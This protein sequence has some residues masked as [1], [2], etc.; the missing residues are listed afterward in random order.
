MA[1]HQSQVGCGL[2]IFCFVSLALTS[3][4]VMPANRPFS[5]VERGLRY[6]HCQG[7]SSAVKNTSSNFLRESEAAAVLY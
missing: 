3:R 4:E 5:N 2:R 7:N 1:Q 6:A